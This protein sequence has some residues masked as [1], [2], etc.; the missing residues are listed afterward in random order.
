MDPLGLVLDGREGR[1]R[2]QSRILAKGLAVV[3][4]SLNI[5]GFPKSL[6]GDIRCADRM[7]SSVRESVR[8]GGGKVVSETG[9]LNGAGYAVL[10]GVLLEDEGVARLLKERCIALEEEFPWGRAVD[11]DVITT[12]GSLGRGEVGKPPR[13]CLVCGDDAKAC[14]RERR[15]DTRSLRE[16]ISLQYTRRSD[17]WSIAAG[18]YLLLPLQYALIW[19]EYY[20]L[21]TLVI[22]VYAFLFL[23]MLSALHADTPRFLE[24]S[25][26][27]QWGLMLSIYCISHVP[28]LLALKIPGYAGRDLLLIAF[29]VI[30]V[31]SSDI[32]QYIVGKLTRGFPLVRR[33]V[34][35]MTVKTIA[36]G[37]CSAALMGLLLWWMTPFALWQAPLIALL[38]AVL[39]MFGNLLMAAIKRDRG[40]D[41]WGDTI[42]GYGSMLDKLESV[43]FA[44]PIFFHIIH[45]GWV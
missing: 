21:Y 17:H 1:A 22:P 15:H 6:P 27:V 9:L 11:V 13:S 37:L 28:A 38:I 18:F 31:Q 35:E 2:Q 4:V 12:R 8:S 36:A 23:P 42:V 20:N 45:A 40:I 5:P 26:K 32:A 24:R 19:L 41:S 25:S 16:F 3:Q 34:P 7:A 14:G 43:I 39:G 44:A 33:L 30:V 10:I 29:L